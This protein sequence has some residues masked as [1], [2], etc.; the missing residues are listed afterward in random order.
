MAVKEAAKPL[1]SGL[2]LTWRGA[3]SYFGASFNSASCHLEPVLRDSPVLREIERS[4]GSS[5]ACSRRNLP[6]VSTVITPRTPP[7]HQAA[8]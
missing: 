7:L 4:D 5:L 6:I 1:S 2:S 8:G 3:R